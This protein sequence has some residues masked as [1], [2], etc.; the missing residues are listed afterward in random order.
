M[1]KLKRYTSLKG[2]LLRFTIFKIG[3]LHIRYH[4]IRSDDKTPFFH[5]HP[6]HYISI[7]LQGGYTEQSKHGESNFKRGNILFRKDDF[8]HRIKDVKPST[9]TLFITW[10]TNREWNLEI[11]QY[12]IDCKNWIEL[13]P[14]I[15][16]RVLGGKERYAKFD[17]FWFKSQDS[18]EK[19]KIEI[20]PS[21]NQSKNGD[22][23]CSFF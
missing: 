16:K 13:K 5:N 10:K 21:V 11:P 9:K 8:F 15:Y 2:Y 12:E 23:I 6:F 14:G 22:F 19:A 18:I 3:R 17:K 7:I 1:L 20:N 4:Y